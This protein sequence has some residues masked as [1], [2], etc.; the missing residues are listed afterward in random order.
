MYKNFNVSEAVWRTYTLLSR[1]RPVVLGTEEA[2]TLN[3]H[4]ECLWFIIFSNALCNISHRRASRI[5][6]FSVYSGR[7][8]LIFDDE[9]YLQARAPIDVLRDRNTSPLLKAT[10]N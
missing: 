10:K 6:L 8:V 7:A 1:L 3:V 2:R 5:F 9:L 4:L